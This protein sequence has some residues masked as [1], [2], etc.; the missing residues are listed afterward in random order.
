MWTIL[1]VRSAVASDKEN[2]CVEMK[3][4]RENVRVYG[5]EL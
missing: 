1:L 4:V 2:I 5:F 3:R